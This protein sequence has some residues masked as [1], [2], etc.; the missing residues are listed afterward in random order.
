LNGTTTVIGR[1]GKTSATAD[2]DKD[3]TAANAAMTILRMDRKEIATDRRRVE[4]KARFRR[5]FN[6]LQTVR[7]AW[8]GSAC[9]CL[10]AEMTHKAVAERKK[11][12]PR[13]QAKG[14]RTGRR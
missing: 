9:L 4:I 5:L 12:T 10:L 8:L 11:I 14:R 1:D 7:V 6:G 2:P 3:K 13:K